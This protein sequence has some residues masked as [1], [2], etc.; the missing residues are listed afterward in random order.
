MQLTVVRIAPRHPCRKS[1][2]TPGSPPG[3][4]S[5][6]RGAYCPMSPR[7]ST[8]HAL[9]AVLCAVAGCNGSSV[10]LSSGAGASPSSTSS[11]GATGGSGGSGGQGGSAGAGAEGGGGS[12]SC[13]ATEIACGKECVN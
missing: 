13:G 1:T 5:T 9:L 6:A 8:I 3:A 7:A 4:D 11:H 10:D 2:L 12:P